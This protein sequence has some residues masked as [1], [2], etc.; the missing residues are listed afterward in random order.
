MAVHVIKKGLDLPITG[1]PEQVIESAKTSTRVAL[2]AADYVGMRPSLFVQVGDMVQRGQVLFEDK[3]I[4][5][6]L[7]TA[8]GAG[9][10]AAINRGAK[11]ALQTV[12]V[13]LNENERNGAPAEEDFASFERYTGKDLALLDSAQVEALLV[14]SGLWTA[15]RTR[16]FS[17]TPAPGTRPHSIFVTAM[18]SNP[19]AP[20]MDV[21]AEGRDEDLNMGLLAVAKVT[22][23]RVYFCKAAGSKITPS[24]NSSAIT[25]EFAGPHPSG[26]PGL[27]IHLLDAVSREKTVWHIGLQDVLAIGVLFRTG[28][29][30]VDGVISLAGPGVKH[31]RLLRTRMGASLDELVGG[32]LKDGEQRLVSGSVLSG[33]IAMGEVLGYLGRFHNQV[34]VLHE[35]REREFLGWMAPG[36]DKFSISSLFLSKLMPGKEFDLTTTTH[37]S[38]RAIVPIGLY[39]RIMPMDIL[40]TFLLRSLIAGDL[41]RSEELGCLELDE[42]DLALCTFVASG[43]TEY[44]PILRNILTTI[45]KE[46]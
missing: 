9:R 43:K 44:G 19:L 27:H 28:K 37:G 11:R 36:A 14:E 30:D 39:E 25:E 38:P 45:E 3:K 33:R 21:I 26:L 40:P 1:A 16:P 18:D 41:D 35:G 20:S 17:R 2:V 12:V 7:N 5:G 8:P 42:E 24:T 46:G 15:F 13:E 34:S 31:P 22:D 4:P 6:V 29:L 10:V 23:G 32:E